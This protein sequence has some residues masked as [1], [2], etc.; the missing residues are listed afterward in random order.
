[1]ARKKSYRDLS[2]QLNRIREI[3]SAN[4]NQRNLLRLDRAENAFNRY[5][6]NIADTRKWERGTSQYLQLMKKGES[7]KARAII[8]RD[9]DYKFSQRTYMGMSNG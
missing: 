7:K 9:L 3:A 6:N 2:A 4:N 1:M 5:A 8:D